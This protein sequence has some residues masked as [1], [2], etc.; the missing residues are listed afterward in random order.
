MVGRMEVAAA[1]SR[2]LL[3]LLCATS[4]S[5]DVVKEPVVCGICCP[6]GSNVRCGWT[7]VTPVSIATSRILL[8]RQSRIMATAQNVTG[9]S[10]FKY[11]VG[12]KNP[13]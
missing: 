3:G 1:V 4:A 2:Y 10:S 12:D 9:A 7:S 13:W 11:E 6:Q 8:Y 5:G